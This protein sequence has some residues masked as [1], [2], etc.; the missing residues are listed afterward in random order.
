[1]PWTMGA[2]YPCAL[3]DAK[4]GVACE[5][6]GE[7]GRHSGS[8][9]IARASVGEEGVRRGGT[10]VGEEGV[11]K[12]EKGKGACEVNEKIHVRERLSHRV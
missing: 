6:D 4:R 1:V 11:E 5:Y 7:E 8:G 9:L 10:H 3:D 2:T 12:K